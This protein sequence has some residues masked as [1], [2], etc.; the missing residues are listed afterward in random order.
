MIKIVDHFDSMFTDYQ[1]KRMSKL[2]T[3]DDPSDNLELI[4]ISTLNPGDRVD[5]LI[6]VSSISSDP[7]YNRIFDITAKNVIGRV[8]KKDGFSYSDCDNIKVYIRPGG[9]VITTKGNHR[10][11]MKIGVDGYKKSTQNVVDEIKDAFP[12]ATVESD[13]DI[14]DD[15][16]F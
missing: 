13:D 5:G 2:T 8:E 9:I 11:L 14:D 15:I 12:G 3:I 16:P 1:K 10:T 4:D 7:V 6:S